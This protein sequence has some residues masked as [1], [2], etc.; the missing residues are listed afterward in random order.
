MQM[1]PSPLITQDTIGKSRKRPVSFL[2]SFFTFR[3]GTQA[4]PYI[5][6]GGANRVCPPPYNN[7]TNCT[8]SICKREKIRLPDLH[9]RSA[10]L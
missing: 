9:F 5:T 10:V 7:F 1:S 8:I 3:N 4:V 2:F 6:F